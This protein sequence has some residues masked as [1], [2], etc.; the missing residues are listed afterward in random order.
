MTELDIINYSR[1]EF[2]VG[3]LSVGAGLTLGVTIAG[4]AARGATPAAAEAGKSRAFISSF[5]PNIFI[6]VG[7]DNLVTVLSKHVE[8]GQG[9]YTGLATLVA[10]RTRRIL[11]TNEGGRRSRQRRVVQRFNLG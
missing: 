8:M 10:G 9:V 5:E 6:R 11:D 1:R 3:G 2:L 7:I 4:R